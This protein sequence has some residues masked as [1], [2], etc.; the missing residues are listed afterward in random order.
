MEWTDPRYLEKLKS[1]SYDICIDARESKAGVESL[2]RQRE[3]V[4]MN[5]WLE[6]GV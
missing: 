3:K 5:R 6:I 4:Q 2:L 1:K